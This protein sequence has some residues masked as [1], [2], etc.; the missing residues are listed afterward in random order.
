[1]KFF[2]AYNEKYF[3]G[4]VKNNLI[5][6]DTG[7]KLQHCFAMPFEQKFNVIAQP[8]GKLHNLLKGGEYA[9]YV[10]RITGG[11]TWHTYNF[12]K[13]LI[14]M[15]REL[16]GD[17]FLGFQLHEIFSNRRGEWDS[18]RKKFGDPPYDLEQF[19]KENIASFAKLPDG[20]PLYNTNSDPI[21]FF[22]AHKYPESYQDAIAD[23]KDML[24]R[25]MAEVDGLILPCDSAYQ[26][27]R[28]ENE[29]GMK[30]FM[31][32]VGYQIPQMRQE[33]AHARGIAEN[34]GKTWGVYYETWS[35][36]GN[37]ENY[38][39]A[40]YNDEP[41]NEWFLSQE[42]HPDD[43]TTYGENGGSSRLLQDRIYHYALMAG[44]HYVSEEWG[45]NCSYSDM[46][47]FVLSPYGIV[48][49]NFIDFAHKVGK[50]RPKVPFA[51]VL[52]TK[53]EVFEVG[54]KIEDREFRQPWDIYLRTKLDAEDTAYFT[55]IFDV[56][57]YIYGRVNPIGNE[58]RTITNSRF[59]DLFDIIYADAGQ[60]VFNRYEAL[61]DISPDS[62]FARSG[63]AGSVP[64]FETTDLPAMEAGIKEIAKKVLPCTVDCLM[65]M[66]SDGEDGTQYLSIF[67][68]EGNDRTPQNGDNISA[69]ADQRA[70]VTF[71][72]AGELKVVKSSNEN[73][74]LQ[75]VDEKTWYVDMPAT[76][77]VILSY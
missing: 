10:D 23:Y 48:K 37:W 25:R 21:E 68:N 47:E 14:R 70:T 5:N 46:K 3:D 7:F 44:A 73:I 69:D 18:I 24:R 4:L 13:N 58:G 64:V 50:I 59:G 61:I 55:H 66:L 43:F 56:K 72:D 51:I 60:D 1:M 9:F 38:S 53:Y 42:E 27:I 75:R 26:G 57:K 28:I 71:K 74:K 11:I 22:A 77:F 34:N 67:N 76:S 52:P 20:T 41:G 45:L 19:K 16:L 6:S 31:P 32:E 39:I 63:N 36:V 29:M 33:V 65:W 62:S 12:D 8:D 17:D 49:K 35:F 40:C 30:T 2:H 15:Y 54:R